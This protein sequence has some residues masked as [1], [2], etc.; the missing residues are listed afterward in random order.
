MTIKVVSNSTPLIALSLTGSGDG[1]TEEAIA[2][3]KSRQ[4]TNNFIEAQTKN[5]MLANTQTILGSY[6][7]EKCSMMLVAM[8][9]S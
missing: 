6:D 1:G 4:F 2:T 3:L 8:R 9:N 7:E 5:K